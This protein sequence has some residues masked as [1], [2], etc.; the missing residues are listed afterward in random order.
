MWPLCQVRAPLLL[1]LAWHSNPGF[2]VSDFGACRWH[3]RSD[4]TAN[5]S[6][7]GGAGARAPGRAAARSCHELSPFASVGTLPPHDECYP[8]VRA[9]L[10]LFP[11]RPS[12]PLPL[13]RTLASCCTTGPCEGTRDRPQKDPAACFH[14]PRPG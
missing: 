14:S 13:S 2:A 10:G 3:L 5:S 12:S 9:F 4:A 7:F 8:A 6:S 1:A 11:S